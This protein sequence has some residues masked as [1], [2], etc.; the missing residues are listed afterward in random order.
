MSYIRRT[1]A[2]L[3]IMGLMSVCAACHIYVDGHPLTTEELRQRLEEQ[4]GA[5]NYELRQVDKDHWE[6]SLPRYPELRYTVTKAITRGGVIPLPRHSSVENRMEK[7]GS[8]L[9][10]KYFSP[11]EQKNI[12]YT[13][14][15]AG[16]WMQIEVR[17]DFSDE[18]SIADLQKKVEA[19]VK[20]MRENYPAVAG[21]T[22]VT[23]SVRTTTE[24]QE[25]A[26][27]KDASKKTESPR[28]NMRKSG[29]VDDRDI[30]N[31]L[32]AVY[33]KGNADYR[34]SEVYPGEYYIRLKNYP[35]FSFRLTVGRDFY[36]RK[37]LSDD[38]YQDAIDYLRKEFAERVPGANFSLKLD[39]KAC[40][41]ATSADL[42]REDRIP[43]LIEFHTKT[44]D[45]IQEN[46]GLINADA[47]EGRSGEIP[48]LSVSLSFDL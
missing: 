20:D 23:L 18:K 42:S 4:Y 31:Y 40:Q 6:V 11:E 17:S 3:L 12:S 36:G 38:R 14:K 25:K 37:I 39:Y 7:L 9:V 13:S 46:A 10:P 34:E 26:L 33:G 2:V 27:R 45:F 1:A 48:L 29:S 5:G 22:G 19:L 16:G 24:D 41:A 21:G 44:L 35:D 32:E 43:D 30:S 15:Y 28:M 8:L 47:P